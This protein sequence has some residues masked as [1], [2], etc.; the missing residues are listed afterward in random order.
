MREKGN[1]ESAMKK[2]D[3]ETYVL[4]YAYGCNGTPLISNE[5][6]EAELEKQRLLWNHL[7]DIQDQVDNE[8]KQRMIEEIPD[9]KEHYQ[10]IERLT[11]EILT[12]TKTRRIIRHENKNTTSTP[13]LDEE[14]KMLSSQRYE[15]KKISWDLEKK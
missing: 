13:E 8:I 15:V 12:A 4:A 14:I 2:T 9:L 10:E 3:N 5:Y 7:L 1:D 6:V 11:D